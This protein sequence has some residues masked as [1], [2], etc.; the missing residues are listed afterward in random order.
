MTA[1]PFPNVELD[2][3]PAHQRRDH[4]HEFHH[5]EPAAQAGARAVA[6]G[7]EGARGGAEE[8]GGADVEG[9]VEVG[10]LCAGMVVVVVVAVVGFDIR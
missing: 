1:D 3:I 10:I 6:E 4:S 8:R 9:G 7:D 2:A 5:R